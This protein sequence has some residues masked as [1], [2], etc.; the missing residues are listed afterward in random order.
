MGGGIASGAAEALQ[1]HPVHVWGNERWV[2]LS[3]QLLLCFAGEMAGDG[4]A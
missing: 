2:L 1:V 4:P 3:P